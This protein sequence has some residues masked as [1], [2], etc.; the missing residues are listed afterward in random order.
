MVMSSGLCEPLV[1][2]FPGVKFLIAVDFRSWRIGLALTD[3]LLL[4]SYIEHLGFASLFRCFTNGSWN[5]DV[6]DTLG[7]NKLVFNGI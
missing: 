6:F 3:W 2:P 5:F 7:K 4:K 1:G